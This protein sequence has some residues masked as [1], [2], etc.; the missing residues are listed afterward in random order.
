MFCGGEDELVPDGQRWGEDWDFGRSGTGPQEDR[1][2][3][4][5]GPEVHAEGDGGLGGGGRLFGASRDADGRAS[6]R[7]ADQLVV[8]DWV[9]RLIT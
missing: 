2:E 3:T 8:A 9:A 5:A 4:R 6:G 7:A 1:G